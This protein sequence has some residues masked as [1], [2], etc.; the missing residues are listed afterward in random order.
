MGKAKLPTISREEYEKGLIEGQKY[1]DE[2]PKAIDARFDPDTKSLVLEME[3]GVT[4]MVPV[5]LIQG[6]Q[7]DDIAALNDFELLFRGTEIHWH[8]LDVQFTIRSLINGRFGT[9]KWMSSLQQHLSDIGRK[10]GKAKTPAKRTASIANGKKGGRPKKVTQ[11]DLA[12]A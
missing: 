6:L 3:S 2:M 5:S 9:Q 4:C 1:L 10:G 7:T 12:A 8:S 11:P